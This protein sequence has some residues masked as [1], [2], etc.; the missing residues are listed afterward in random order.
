MSRQ[1]KVLQIIS[2]V[3]ALAVGIFIYLIDRQPN[4]VYFLPDWFSLTGNLKPVFG[5]LGNCLPTFLHTFAFVLLTA[6]FVTPTSSKLIFICISWFSIESL[7][8]FGQISSVALWIAD[9]V[10]NWFANIPI[11]NNTSAY[12]ISGT[13]DI[14]DVVSIA[15][16]VVVAYVF[17]ASN[18]T[19]GNGHV[20]ES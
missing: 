11:L 5:E 20:Y 9:H 7:F 14:R 3:F 17:V 6:I 19:E 4:S 10:P 12:F 15:A 8:E 13:F 1:H 16:G 18:Q 2:A